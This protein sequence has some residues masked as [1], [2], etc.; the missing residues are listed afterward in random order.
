MKV[1]SGIMS[2]LSDEWPTPVKLFEE[3][4]KEFN[5]NLDVCADHFNH[6]CARYYTVEDDGLTKLWGGG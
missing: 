1:T 4:N 2:S 3:L 5:F 6:K